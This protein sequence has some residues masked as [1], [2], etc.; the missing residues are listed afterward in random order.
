M[1]KINFF[2]LTLVIILTGC[3]QKE[4]PTDYSDSDLPVINLTDLFDQGMY[5]ERTAFNKYFH[6]PKAFFLEN[7]SEIELNEIKK[8]EITDSLFFILYQ[9]KLCSYTS[10]GKY[11]CSYN[12]NAS[13]FD[14]DT[15]SSRII[16]YD[17]SN[18]TIS[19]Y[20]YGNISVQSYKIDKS[21]HFSDIKYLNDNKLLLTASTFPDPEVYIFDMNNSSLKPLTNAISNKNINYDQLNTKVS[22]GHEKSSIPPLFVFNANG[23]S[24]FFKYLFSDT[25]YRYD[26]GHIEPVAIINMPVGSISLT[27]KGKIDK[28]K[29]VHITWFGETSFGYLIK[30]Q[31]LYKYEGK[32]YIMNSMMEYDKRSKEKTSNVGYISSGQVYYVN[33]NSLLFINKKGRRL[34]DIKKYSYKDYNTITDKWE[35]LDDESIKDEN[36]KTNLL[37]TSYEI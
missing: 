31:S 26:S 17:N 11:Y 7:T 25:L 23:D 28:K 35:K 12:V 3:R 6:D 30:Y 22:K 13:T 16:I 36:T 8:A 5:Y 18:Q 4:K 10:E 1:S 21:A 2:I 15:V 32:K 9:N 14:I 29:F 19:V 27:N 24:L 34:Y 20:T 37:V 33:P